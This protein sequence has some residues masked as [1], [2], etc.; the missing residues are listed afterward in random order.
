MTDV[1]AADVEEFEA[2]AEHLTHY[3][4]AFPVVDS[5]TPRASSPST[6]R[7]ADKGESS[8]F[9]SCQGSRSG[10]GP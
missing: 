1:I 10:G 3:N 5:T 6:T 4:L 8:T 7:S 2:V 9:S